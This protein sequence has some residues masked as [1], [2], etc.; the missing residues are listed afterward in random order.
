MSSEIPPD[1]DA[2]NEQLQRA[3]SMRARTERNGSRIR[4]GR[5]ATIVIGLILSVV[6]GILALKLSDADYKTAGGWI[7]VG[8]ALL[9][10][11]AALLTTKKESKQFGLSNEWR[12]QVADVASLSRYMHGA[13]PDSNKVMHAWEHIRSVRTRLENKELDPG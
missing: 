7:A 4:R 13:D 10:S 12:Q 8:T 6:S 3:E 9:T 11:A 2:L 1:A 5:Q